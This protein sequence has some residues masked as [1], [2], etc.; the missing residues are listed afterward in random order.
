MQIATAVAELDNHFVH[1]ERFAPLE[2]RFRFLIQKRFAD[3]AAGRNREAHGLTLTGEAG[4]G[5]T[6]A[7][8]HLL[9]RTQSWITTTDTPGMKIIRLDVPARPSLRALGHKVIAALG[10]PQGRGGEGWYL[11]GLIRHHVR[12]QKVVFIHLDE[13]QHLAE[14]RNEK[15]LIATISELKTMMSDSDWPVGILMS[16]TVQLEDLLNR[17]PQISRRMEAVHF[18]PIEALSQTENVLALTSAYC[19]KA[20]LEPEASIDTV[21]FVERLV[22]AAARQFGLMIKLICLAIEQALLAEDKYLG[23]VHFAMGYRNKAD[24]SDTF[25]PFIIPDFYRVDPRQIFARDRS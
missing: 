7:V 2:Q 21:E 14:H 8:R 24:C 15:E 4:A 16:G 17:D 23:M 6:T 12:E 1:H 22:H 19:S 11:W 3:L 25:N 10:Y 18:G 5:K 13:A 20:C 9:A